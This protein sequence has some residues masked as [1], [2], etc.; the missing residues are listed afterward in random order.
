MRISMNTFFLLLES[1]DLDA[2]ILWNTESFCPES[3][4][5]RDP[6]GTLHVL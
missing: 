5:L 4:I 1:D 6:D 3:T 2:M